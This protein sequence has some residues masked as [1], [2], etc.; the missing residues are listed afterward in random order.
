MLPLRPFVDSSHT[1]LPPVSGYIVGQIPNN[2]A[3]Q[4]V[5]PRI[6]LASM[7]VL[8]SGLSM[9][10]AAAK[11]PGHV[12]AIRFFQA[13]AESSTVCAAY[14]PW[15]LPSLL[16]EKSLIMHRSLLPCLQFSGSHFL[17]G[18]WV[19]INWH[20][21]IFFPARSVDATSPPSIRSTKRRSLA[22]AQESS[23]AVRSWVAFSAA[24]SKEQVS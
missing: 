3:L 2:L 16:L 5:P 12:M 15:V 17:L 18:C 20:G 22:S 6:W 1:Y 23:P 7:A 24:C 19:R 9:C 11:S 13:L 10:L 8:W 4:V 21:D 14:P